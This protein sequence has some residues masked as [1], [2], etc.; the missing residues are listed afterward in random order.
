MRS[1]VPILH[2]YSMIET[3]CKE[4]CYKYIKKLT[5]F[6]HILHN[7]LIPGSS[8]AVSKFGTKYDWPQISFSESFPRFMLPDRLSERTELSA[9][10]EIRAV[11]IADQFR[12]FE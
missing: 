1:F 8:G 9:E 11:R 10:F 6:L 3:V 5:S 12:F 4:I 2:D 7:F